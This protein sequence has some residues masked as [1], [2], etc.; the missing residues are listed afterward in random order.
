MIY[1]QTRAGQQ[2]F[3]QD[4]NV[5][6]LQRMIQRVEELE[7]LT[8]ELK[9]QHNANELIDVRAILT[10][11]EIEIKTMKDRI[12]ELTKSK[13]TIQA[14]FDEGDLYAQFSTSLNEKEQ[15]IGEL[16][17]ELQNTKNQKMM[18]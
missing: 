10:A 4:P 1:L 7:D 11:K 14:L 13:L 12:S 16:R 6:S 3:G 5:A 18:N 2:I 17:Q 15:I 9:S 8:H